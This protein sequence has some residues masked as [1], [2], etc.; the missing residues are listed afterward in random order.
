MPDLPNTWSLN[1]IQG[2]GENELEVTMARPLP[3]ELAPGEN[4]LAI[5]VHLFNG[6]NSNLRLGNVTLVEV[7]PEVK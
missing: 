5:S 6:F 1:A 4:T 7:E 2:L 3:G